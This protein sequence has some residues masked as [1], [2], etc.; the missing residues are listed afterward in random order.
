MGIPNAIETNTD[1][2]VIIDDSTS[3]DIS[4]EPHTEQEAEACVNKLLEAL[5]SAVS[6]VKGGLD[7]ASADLVIACA[8]GDILDLFTDQYKVAHAEVLI[9]GQVELV[10][11]ESRKFKD[12]LNLKFLFAVKMSCKPTAVKAAIG[13]LSAIAA[14]MGE[15]KTLHNRVAFYENALWYDLSHPDG[16]AIRITENGYEMLK[17][18]SGLFR[19]FLNQVPQVLPERGGNIL[20]IFDYFNVKG[21]MNKLLFLV[22]LIASFI[23][24]IAHAI[25]NVIGQQGSGKTDAFRKIKAIVDPGVKATD[26]IPGTTDQLIKKLYNS[27]LILFDNV[28]QFTSKQSDVI[29]TAITGAGFSERR[30]Y[31]NMDEIILLLRRVIAINGIAPLVQKADLMDRCVTI[32]FS[33]I[34][35]ER[36]MPEKVLDVEF[37][38]ALP[39]ILDAIFDILSKAMRIYPSVEEKLQGSLPRMAD[40]AVWGVSIT[41]A[42]G[43]SGNRFLAAYHQ[44]INKQSLGIVVENAVA[45]V[46]LSFMK[47]RDEWEGSSHK[48]LMELEPVAHTMDKKDKGW[49]K[50]GRGLTRKLSGL[51]TNL[52]DMGL[53]I[54]LRI[55]RETGN[56][57]RISNLLWKKPLADGTTNQALSSASSGISSGSEPRNEAVPQATEDN[58]D[59]SDAIKNHADDEKM[60][61]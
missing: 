47:D 52:R 29:C 24:N 20:R 61:A 32:E 15:R 28:S 16:L 13:T 57:L 31:T 8:K 30:L 7:K 5:K 23:P 41:E 18:P 39:G 33:R 37:Q 60:K 50:E 26:N 36:R 53:D 49:P 6:G 14:H 19:P 58:E 35:P 40:F 54:E 9:N 3:G 2:D 55:H 11:I 46:L 51:K 25:L 38:A 17:R 34:P 22:W 44:N 56:I 27:W 42:M 4:G 1:Q 43:I 45:H 59:K 12:F 10:P 21:A 48:L